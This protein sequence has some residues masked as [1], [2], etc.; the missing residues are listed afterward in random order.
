VGAFR[1]RFHGSGDPCHFG[2]GSAALCLFVAINRMGPFGPPRLK[3]KKPALRRVK[4]VDPIRFELT[5]SAMPLR[6]SA[7]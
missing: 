4:M 2:C 7:N 6:R 1:N 5:T 3:T